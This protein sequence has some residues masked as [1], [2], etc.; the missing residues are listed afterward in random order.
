VIKSNG[1]GCNAVLAAAAIADHRVMRLRMLPER[2]V[3]LLVRLKDGTCVVNFHGSSRVKLAEEELQTLWEGAIA[4]SAGSPLVLGGDLN[5][6]TPAAPSEDIAH[7]ARR[8][9]DH[10][11]AR[12]LAPC[13]PAEVLDRRLAIGDRL[14]ELSDHPPLLCTLKAPGIRAAPDAVAG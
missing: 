8:D 7:V 5:L 10:L 13:A 12:E 2:R 1:G 11:F 9:V 6:R 14:V 3:G 4:F